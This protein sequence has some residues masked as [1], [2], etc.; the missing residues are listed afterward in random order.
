MQEITIGKFHLCGSDETR[1]LIWIQTDSGEG[2]EFKEKEL[3][4]VISKFY[5]EKF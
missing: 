5:N 1:G 3:E 2:A 4:E